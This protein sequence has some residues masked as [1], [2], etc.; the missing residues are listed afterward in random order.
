APGEGG[1]EAGRPVAEPVPI[2]PPQ[3]VWGAARGAQSEAGWSAEPSRDGEEIARA[4]GATSPREPTASPASADAR[5][6]DRGGERSGEGPWHGAP[7][8]EVS[9]GE[10]DDDNGEQ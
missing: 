1:G 2:N 9:P 8:A 10:S 3:G 4:G 7:G 5:E 6:G